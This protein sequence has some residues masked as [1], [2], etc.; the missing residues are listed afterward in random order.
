MDKIILA[1]QEFEVI[2]LPLGRLRRLIGSINRMNKFGLETDEAMNEI[3]NIFGLLIG[4]T[5]AEIDEMPI[6]LREMQIA[7]EQIPEICGLVERKIESGE[8][9]AGTVGTQSTAI[10]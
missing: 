8:A 2:E 4:K 3:P 6:S 7:M 5:P 9:Q 1:K 10:F